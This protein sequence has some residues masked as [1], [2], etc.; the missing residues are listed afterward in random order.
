M[1]RKKMKTGSALISEGMGLLTKATDAIEKG[2][3]VN[4]NEIAANAE[5]VEELTTRNTYLAEE[6]KTHM[7]IVANFK[8]N[9]L[10]E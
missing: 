6:N 7:K 10:G 3:E 1:L 5:V 8:K 4:T 2:A 9:I